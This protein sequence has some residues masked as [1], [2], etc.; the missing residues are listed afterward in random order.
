MEADRGIGRDALVAYL[1]NL[2]AGNV[3]VIALAFRALV[4]AHPPW[5]PDLAG[6]TRA[7]LLRFADRLGAGTRLGTDQIVSA[8]A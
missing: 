7:A 3:E 5:Y 6:T 2:F 1:A 4:L 8:L